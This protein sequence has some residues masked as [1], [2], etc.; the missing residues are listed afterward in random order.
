LRASVRWAAA[1]HP[2]FRAARLSWKHYIVTGFPYKI[3]PGSLLI[4]FQIY[5]DT[6]SSGRVTQSA[7]PNRRDFV[8]P[9]LA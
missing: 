3:M 9:L 5:I 4:S 8:P 6:F 7:A 1:S 2:T